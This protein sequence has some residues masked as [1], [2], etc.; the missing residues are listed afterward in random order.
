MHFTII[1]GIESNH[2][3]LKSTPR[4]RGEEF[5]PNRILVYP[6]FKNLQMTDNRNIPLLDLP[7]V[8]EEPK[9]GMVPSVQKALR[10]PGFLDGPMVEE[11]ESRFAHF[12]EIV[13]S[14]GV[15]SDTDAVRFVLMAAGVQPDEI[16]LTVH[17]TF[18]G[19]TEAVHRRAL[20]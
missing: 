20:V 13:H 18:T 1:L 16:V 9:R 17:L 10:T 5:L 3:L 14:A 15:S 11:F 7:S 8:L 4:V 19:T 2:H 12:C 6:E